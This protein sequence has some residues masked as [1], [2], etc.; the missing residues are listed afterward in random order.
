MA[1]SSHRKAQARLSRPVRGRTRKPEA[2]LH[3]FPYIET[4]EDRRLL[5]TCTVSNLGDSGG[6]TLRDCIDNRVNP[7]LDNAI[8]LPAGVVRLHTNLS[9]I[10][11]PVTISGPMTDPPQ[12]FIE[13]DDTGFAFIGLQ[14]LGGNST[15]SNIGIGGFKS[16]GGIGLI[17]DSSDFTSRGTDTVQGCYL[18]FGEDMGLVPDPNNEGLLIGSGAPNNLIGGTMAAQFN[19]IANNFS[20][21]M[22]IQSRSTHNRVIGNFIGT[23]E[24]DDAGLG[25]SDGLVVESD[26]NTIGGTTAGER[27]LISG[28][29]GAG[30]NLMGATRNIIE[31]N[32]IGTKASGI[33]ALGNGG[34]GIAVSGNT[35]GTTDCSD[36]PPVGN[37]IGGTFGAASENLISGNMLGGILLS[38]SDCDAIRG[39]VIGLNAAGSSA[40][41]NGTGSQFG[42]SISAGSYNTIGGAA[43]GDR[44]VISGNMGDG[45]QLSGTGN[46]V[47]NDYIGTDFTGMDVRPN[48]GSGVVVSNGNLNRIGAQISNPRTPT[49]LISGNMQSGIQILA[50]AMQTMVQGNFIGTNFDGTQPL[51]NASAL[52]TGLLL[53]AG[54]SVSGG[55][56]QNCI[57]GTYVAEINMK[58]VNACLGGSY[59]GGTEISEY[60]NVISANQGPAG[61]LMNDT[62]PGISITGF[63]TDPFATTSN[64]LVAGNFIG[65]DWTGTLTSYQPDPLTPPV[66]LGNGRGIYIWGR[67][68][69]NMIGDPT[70]RGA[71]LTYGKRN[72]IAGSIY[73]GVAISDRGTSNNALYDNYIGTRI[74][75]T[76]LG[77]LQDDNGVRYGNGE[78]VDIFNGATGNH[79][80]GY[81][82]P[83]QTNTIIPPD[84]SL[85]SADIYGHGNLIAGNLREGVRIYDSNTSQNM[86]QGNHIGD[87]ID[88]QDNIDK[89]LVMLVNG[90]FIGQTIGVALAGFSNGNMIGGTVMDTVNGQDYIIPGGDIISGNTLYGVAFHDSRTYGNRV[91]GDMIGPDLTGKRA[92]MYRDV[93]NDTDYV[94]QPYGAAF[95]NGAGNAVFKLGNTLGGTTSLS[96]NIITGNVNDGVIIFGTPNPLD[97]EALPQYNVVLGNY[98]GTNIDGIDYL[99]DPYRLPVMVNVGNG[100]N[101]I[102]VYFNAHD[103]TIGG[104]APALH[105]LITGNPLDGILIDSEAYNTVIEGNWIGIDARGLRFLGGPGN[106]QNGIEINLGHNDPLPPHDNVIGRTEMMDDGTAFGVGNVISA[107]TLDGI[108]IAG[109]STN[110][111]IQYNKIGT[112]ITGDLR[113]GRTDLG[114]GTTPDANGAYYNGI[115][116]LGDGTNQNMIGGL[117]IRNVGAVDAN[118]GN[119]I[120]FNGN[121]GI[122]IDTGILNTILNNNI[123][124][125]QD[126]NAVPGSGIDPGINLVNG[127]NDLV[128]HPD[129]SWITSAS[130]SMST[131]FL[132]ITGFVPSSFGLMPNTTYILD[133]FLI[134]YQPGSGLGEGEMFV[135]GIFLVTDATGAAVIDPNDPINPAHFSLGTTLDTTYFQWVTMTLTY[136]N[137]NGDPAHPWGDTSDFSDNSPTNN[138]PLTVT[139]SPGDPGAGTVPVQGSA[140][141]TVQAGVSSVGLTLVPLTGLTGSTISAGSSSPPAALPDVAPVADTPAAA[142]D[143]FFTRIGRGLDGVGGSHLGHHV[144]GIV[145]GDLLLEP[146]LEL[147][148]L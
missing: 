85:N 68:T 93:P 133:F 10:L 33:E 16:F 49:N 77:R 35:T 136:P 148:S 79:I 29:M 94:V 9:P 43:A 102:N 86:V 14:V 121:D 117:S 1:R 91:E 48:M 24:V 106:G 66:P 12:A 45:V 87:F 25:N 119:S 141:G 96:R 63:D 64:N 132:D 2:G 98:I 146:S 15:V 54:I 26:L 31:G 103:N 112:D 127:G 97:D 83:D 123:A 51:G 100:G 75:G 89:P 115:H 5:T 134:S 130:Y 3:F 47:L 44:N 46:L 95:Y 61:D 74:G 90:R 42:I 120:G 105:N 50:Q 57:G 92:V 104:T 34:V 19:V 73:S 6:G 59:L 52:S 137:P 70:P 114:N 18:G 39:N 53:N 56:S 84:T 30:I 108:L 144:R 27:N 113:F 58:P 126:P 13:P 22:E 4:L 111:T 55:A 69:N 88:P 101:G 28:N 62:A 71:T 32:Y 124:K 99:K 131:G 60:R 139:P 110:N 135:G 81:I 145:R 8:S 116:I 129:P 143:Q 109:G 80:G 142:A 76:L 138:V 17:L 21:G 128:L 140:V 125:D 20:Y 36:N 78:G 23:D 118:P 147:L 11:V 7:G 72:I 122:L 37:T 67:A 41:P 38:V 65:T 82:R 40:I 107:N